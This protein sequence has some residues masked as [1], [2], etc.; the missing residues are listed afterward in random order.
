MSNGETNLVE[1]IKSMRPEIQPHIYVFAKS[2][3][4]T[5]IK[6]VETIMQFQEAKAT[7]L[8]LRQDEAE[9]HQLDYKF[10]TIRKPKSSMVSFYETLST[11]AHVP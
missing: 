2:S 5:V 6:S 4:Q 10:C 9:K 8:I 3:D 7:S 11:R 1:L